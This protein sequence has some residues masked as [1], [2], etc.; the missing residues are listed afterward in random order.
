M[1]ISCHTE[2]VLY[3]T[4]H[5]QTHSCFHSYG[6]CCVQKHS[7]S[8]ITNSSWFFSPGLPFPS[9][10]SWY[11]QLS[12]HTWIKRLMCQNWLQCPLASLLN[13]RHYKVFGFSP[14]KPISLLVSLFYHTSYPFHPLI[15]LVVPLKY[16]SNQIFISST[17]TLI[18][19]TTY[20]CFDFYPRLLNGLTIFL[21]SS[22][23]SWANHVNP[24][25]EK[26]SSECI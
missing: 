21:A 2:K 12:S 26:T 4:L 24:H 19:I 10:P 13:K 7:F 18:Q 6:L 17:V 16:I 22:Q 1:D 3:L 23:S 20:S 11:I 5:L 14:S 9:I 25:T 8:S 15:L